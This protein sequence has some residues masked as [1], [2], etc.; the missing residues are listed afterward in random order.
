MPGK[1]PK[2]EIPGTVYRRRLKHVRPPER[3]A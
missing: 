3:E 2:V 1:P